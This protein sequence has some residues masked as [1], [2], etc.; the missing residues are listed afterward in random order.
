M[1]PGRQARIE[2]YIFSMVYILVFLDAHSPSPYALLYGAICAA[3]C[4]EI[5]LKYLHGRVKRDYLLRAIIFDTATIP[6]SFCPRVR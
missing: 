1:V 5:S 4:R 6:V 3:S 2:H